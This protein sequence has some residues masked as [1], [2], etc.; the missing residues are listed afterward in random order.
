MS[1]CS[2]GGSELAEP[3]RAMAWGLSVPETVGADLW[4]LHTPL[5]YLLFGMVSSQGG[6][7]FMLHSHMQDGLGRCQPYSSSFHPGLPRQC[8]HVQ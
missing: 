7:V 8:P 2:P 3:R 4:Y 6:A 5:L 1:S